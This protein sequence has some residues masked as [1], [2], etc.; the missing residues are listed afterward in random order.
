VAKELARA[1]K[2]MI[3][4]AMTKGLVEA[5]A[6]RGV[7]PEPILR[8]FGLDPSNLI[9]PEGFIATAKVALLLEEAARATGD[10]FFRLH[11]GAGLRRAPSSYEGSP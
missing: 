10:D 5:I 6:G 3:S 9:D 7:S 8:E 2:P 1:R 11:F 4:L